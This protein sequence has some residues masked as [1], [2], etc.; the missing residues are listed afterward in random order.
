MSFPLLSVSYLTASDLKLC[1][2]DAGEERKM[3]EILYE[4]NKFN[5]LA[6]KLHGRLDFLCQFEI[7]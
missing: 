3:L 5:V 7:K 4:E 6:P 1:F 2:D